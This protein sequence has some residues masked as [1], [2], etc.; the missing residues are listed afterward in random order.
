MYLVS[1]I[2]LSFKRRGVEHEEKRAKSPK[3]DVPSQQVVL[4]L[5]RPGQPYTLTSHYPVP[6]ITKEDEILIKT[7]I[8]GLNPIDWK[9]P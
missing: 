5:H 7:N 8:I 3:I 1:P 6:L 9:A 2:D 4:L